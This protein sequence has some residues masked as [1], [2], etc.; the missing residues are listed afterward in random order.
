MED[1]RQMNLAF[2]FGEGRQAD[3]EFGGA[4]QL[5][6]AVGPG[7]SLTD[8]WLK[9]GGHLIDLRVRVRRT[10]TGID[11][12]VDRGDDERAWWAEDSAPRLKLSVNLAARVASAAASVGMGPDFQEVLLGEMAV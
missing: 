9:G 10:T 11:V 1:G 12:S 3:V 6:I 7:L 2:D 8:L 5:W 4:D